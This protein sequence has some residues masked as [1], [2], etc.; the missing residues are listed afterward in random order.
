MTHF[1]DDIVN[2]GS[3]V[4]L[5]GYNMLLCECDHADIAIAASVL[6]SAKV[7]PLGK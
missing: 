4:V 6:N 1:L 5:Y 7:E 3:M 2:V